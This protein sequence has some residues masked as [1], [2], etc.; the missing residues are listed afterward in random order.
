MNETLWLRP[1][2]AALLTVSLI[3]AACG[4]DDDDGEAPAATTARASVTASGAPADDDEEGETLV[5]SRLPVPVTVSAPG[6]FVPEDADSPDLFAVVQ[7]NFPNGYIDFVQP[8][9]VYTYA[10]ET[11]SDLGAPPADYVDWLT[12]NP[13]ADLVDS[14]DVTVGG[15]QGTRLEMTNYD[16]DPFSL[17]KLSDGSDYHFSYRDRLY[18]HVLD[19]NGTQILVICG[20]E[21]GVN[22]PEFAS[23]CDDV[24]QHVEFGS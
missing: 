2:V 18:I 10:S 14:R 9:Q 20:T 11:E 4:D 3:V 6:L 22:F 13:F 1:A 15:L 16:Y 17:F 8:T 5:S 23:T 19:A 7:Q 24:L 12:S 21:N